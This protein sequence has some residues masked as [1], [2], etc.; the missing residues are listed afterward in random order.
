MTYDPIFII[1][2]F[3][4]RHFGILTGKL[5]KSGGRDQDRRLLPQATSLRKRRDGY[6]DSQR[7]CFH[8][9]YFNQIC[10]KNY[11]ETISANKVTYM[12]SDV[13]CFS[14]EFF[15]N[16]YHRF[17]LSTRSD[18]RC[19]CLKVGIKRLVRANWLTKAFAILWDVGTVVIQAMAVTYGRHHISV[20]S[21]ID[22]KHFCSMLQRSTSPAERDHLV[23][24]LV[25]Y[26]CI[27]KNKRANTLCGCFWRG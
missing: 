5:C 25:E 1:T 4:K 13:H 8:L 27:Y 7:V 22:S 6:S 9:I 10:K 16:V 21:V 17:L 12:R 11:S 18:M 3:Y 24:V 15:N 26:L 2:N 19:L 20:G 14:C 23:G